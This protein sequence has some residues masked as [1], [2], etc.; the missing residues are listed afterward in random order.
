LNPKEARVSKGDAKK[1]KKRDDEPELKHMCVPLDVSSSG[2]TLSPRR[3]RTRR[4]GVPRLSVRSRGHRASRLFPGSESVP[5]L[6]VPSLV[7]HRADVLPPSLPPRPVRR[8]PRRSSSSTT[9]RLVR[10]T[11]SSSTPTS[12]TFP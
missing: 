5:S 4:R 12:S 2:T 11:T 3:P 10:R 8:R 1:K 9:P 6:S 7:R